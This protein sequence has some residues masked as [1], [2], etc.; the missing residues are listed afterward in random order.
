M[1]MIPMLDNP[2]SKLW[3]ED[4]FDWLFLLSS[5]LQWVWLQP[6]PPDVTHTAHQSPQSI[7][8]GPTLTGNKKF[9]KYFTSRPLE[10][11]K[12]R[13]L[14]FLLLLL[15]DFYFFEEQRKECLSVLMQILFSSLFALC[16]LIKTKVILKQDALFVSITLI[17]LFISSIVGFFL[18]KLFA[19]R[20]WYN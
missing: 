12:L 7:A 18:C 13:Y 16:H 10:L 8:A 3:M 5:Y 1:M 14:I 17:W 15:H 11:Q 4:I 19:L 6:G 9:R 2:S 20:N